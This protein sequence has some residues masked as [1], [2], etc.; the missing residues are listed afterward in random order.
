VQED[1]AAVL[2][3][4]TIRKKIT[5][6]LVYQEIGATPDALWSFLLYCGYLK[7]NAKQWTSDGELFAKLAIPN[8]EIRY[9]FREIVFGWFQPD[10]QNADGQYE[11]MLN[12]LKTGGVPMFKYNFQEIVLTAFSYFDVGTRQ[13][14]IVYHAFSLGLLVSMQETHEVRSN[15]ES[16]LGRYD[17]AL[18][19]R[20]PGGTG[21][22]IE[23]KKA[24]SLEDLCHVAEKA[25]KQIETNRYDSEL[26]ERGVSDILRLGIAYFGKR[27]EVIAG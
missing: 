7:V 4:E 8:R 24:E 21:I 26:R 5:D 27:I 25:L 2:R 10:L 18:I 6:A 11:K 22:I 1:L 17:L 12:S 19:P 9:M 16:G 15:R 14:E 3:D 20:N 13:P 23:F